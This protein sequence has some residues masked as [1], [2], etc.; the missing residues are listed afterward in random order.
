MENSDIFDILH[1]HK[2]KI[3]C[4]LCQK[5]FWFYQKAVRSV[6]R[7]KENIWVEYYHLNCLLKAG[8][9]RKLKQ[10]SGRWDDRD[11]QGTSN[12]VH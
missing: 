6:V 9:A 10:K 8:L 12:V 7:T 3:L 5:R 1:R 11:K 4:D 2:K